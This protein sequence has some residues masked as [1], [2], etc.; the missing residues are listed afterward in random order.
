M[1]GIVETP[2]IVGG[3]GGLGVVVGTGA[4]VGA[5]GLALVADVALGT[6]L[7]VGTGLALAPRTIPVG[8]TDARV[9]ALEATRVEGGAA[10]NAGP[11]TTPA[12]ASAPRTAAAPARR[13]FGPRGSVAR[14]FGQKPEMGVVTYPQLRHFTGRRRRAMRRLACIPRARTVSPGSA[15][16]SRGSAPLLALDP[17]RLGGEAERLPLRRG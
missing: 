5:A 13:Q 10:R 16:R 17:R 2:E 8:L 4:T 6:A 12:I 1:A 3:A 14:Q 15:S 11:P 9:V 7:A